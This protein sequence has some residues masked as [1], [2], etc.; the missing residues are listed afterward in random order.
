MITRSLIALLSC[1]SCV[2]QAQ[3]F[4]DEAFD[5]GIPGAWTIQDGGT[6]IDTWFGTTGGYNG[7]FLDGSEFGLVDSDGAG[8]NGDTLSE[9][10]VTPVLNT[11]A[12][13]ALFLEYDHFYNMYTTADTGYLEIFDGAQWVTLLKYFDV[14]FGAWAAPE[15]VL[16]DITA[17]ANANMQ[18]RFRYEDFGTWAWYWAV[19]NVLVYAQAAADAGVLAITSPISAC[20]L[21]AT[22]QVVILVHNYG[23]DTIQNFDVAYAI[24][25]GTSVVETLNQTLAPGDTV[26]HIFTQTTNLQSLGPHTVEAWTLLAGDGDNNNDSA[27]TIVDNAHLS[28]FPYQQDFETGPGGWTTIGANNSWEFGTPNAG[29]IPNAASGDNAWVTNLSGNHNNLEWAFLVSPC[30]DFSS[31]LADPI[32]S[33]SL[34]HEIEQNYDEAWLEVSIDGGQNWTKVGASGSGLSWYNDVN[35]QTWEN[36]SGAAGDWVIAEQVVANT[37]GEPSVK[38]RF[39]FQSDGSVTNAGI[40][41]D[42]IEITPPPENDLGII[43]LLAPQNGC[44]DGS[45][46]NVTVKIYNYGTTTQS[47][48]EVVYQIDGGIPVYELV[49]NALNY[50]DTLTYTFATTANLGGQGSHSITVATNLFTDQVNTNNGMYN[51][52]IMNSAATP[53]SQL[54]SDSL[55]ITGLQPEGLESNIIFC[56]MPDELGPCFRIESLTIDSLHHTSIGEVELYLI[57][58]AGDTLNVSIGNGG[59]GTSYYNVT[60]SD[61]SSNS[62]T[63]FFSGIPSGIYHPEDSVGFASFDGQNPN[64]QWTLFVYDPSGL[65]DGALYD[66]SLNFASYP[67]IELGTDAVLC[68]FDSLYLDAG[69]GFSSYNWSTGSSDSILLFDASQYPIGTVIVNLEVTDSLGCVGSDSVH[70]DI[71]LCTGVDEL[72]RPFSAVIYPNPTKD[73]FTIKL[74]Q[75]NELLIE[76]YD[77]IG[78]LVIQEKRVSDSITIDI[79]NH[80]PGVYLVKLTNEEGQHFSRIVKM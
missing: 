71:E 33:F 22:E 7:N 45:P 39:V 10:L 31:M 6:S 36:N 42:D 32:I 21:S 30:F 4:L 24:N 14:D 63:S 66:W 53:W 44:G 27:V 70:V 5:S 74:E 11:S 43:A 59:L 35:D 68:D 16:I 57:S 77:E 51:L 38:L 28:A 18:V 73:N 40:G 8:N 54:V 69:F 55:L 61:T 78:R 75:S 58:P 15:H 9:G 52:S 13:V 72:N 60:F 20:N 76:V 2:A 25:G 65:E 48:F 79:S 3:T 67:Q 29:F 23:Y 41:I 1:F 80:P 49:P 17:Y 62:V 64:G 26:P 50:T 47:G 37:A 34:I 12:A 46:A 56:G 19:D